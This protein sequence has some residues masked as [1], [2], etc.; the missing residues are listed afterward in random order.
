MC[1]TVTPMT[2]HEH[3]WFPY[4][5]DR[6]RYLIEWFCRYCQRWSSDP[7]GVTTPCTRLYW[8]RASQ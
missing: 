5:T 7:A 3:Q 8:L 1:A 2:E 4:W 6:T